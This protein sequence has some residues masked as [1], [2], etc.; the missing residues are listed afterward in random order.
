VSWD[1]I[2]ECRAADV[3]NR[4]RRDLMKQLLTFAEVNIRGAALDHDDRRAVAGLL[5][6][7]RIYW[8]LSHVYPEFEQQVAEMDRGFDRLIE[9][10]RG[11][12]LRWYVRTRDPDE[13]RELGEIV[14]QIIAKGGWDWRA[15]FELAVADQ[16]A[17]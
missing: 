17:S 9:V 6:L 2:N 12:L 8:G 11:R 15:E 5:E 14:G 16:V 4:V 13:V 1:I 7:R 10:G 3:Y